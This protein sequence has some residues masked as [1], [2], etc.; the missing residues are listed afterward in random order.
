[1][2]RL[3]DPRGPLPSF[4]PQGGGRFTR[5]RQ[6]GSRLR[7]DLFGCPTSQNLWRI[8]LYREQLQRQWIREAHPSLAKQMDLLQ[9]LFVQ[10]F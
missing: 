9:P 8:S 4:L 6:T 10:W 7:H 3:P 5:L 1:M 2:G